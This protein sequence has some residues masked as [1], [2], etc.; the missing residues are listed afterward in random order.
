M[1][2]VQSSRSEEDWDTAFGITFERLWNGKK[3]IITNAGSTFKF[4][5]SASEKGS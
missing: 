1:A 5:I 2:G 3:P 4:V